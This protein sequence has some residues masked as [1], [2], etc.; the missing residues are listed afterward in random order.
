LQSCCRH[1]HEIGFF[2]FDERFMVRHTHTLDRAGGIRQGVG[3]EPWSRL[4]RQMVCAA[5][6]YVIRR[7]EA[8]K[9]G[10]RG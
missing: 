4:V 7:Y 3:E 5:G 1:L 9:S 2:S 10:C 8:W 6:Q